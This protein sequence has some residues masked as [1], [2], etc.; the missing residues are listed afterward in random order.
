MSP[1]TDWD[2]K[3]QPRFA[4]HDRENDR[5]MEEDSRLQDTREEEENPT[6]QHLSCL[7]LLLLK[8]LK[9]PTPM[10]TSGRPRRCTP[11]LLYLAR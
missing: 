8:N 2:C 3:S 10:A 7:R 1:W 5:I 6:V 9:H 11:Y 4:F